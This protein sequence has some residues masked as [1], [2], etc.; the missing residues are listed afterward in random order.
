MSDKI[1]AARQRSRSTIRYALTSVTH[2]SLTVYDILGR[3]VSKLV[4]DDEGP[5]YHT[6]AWDAP[7]NASGVY[8]YM[9]RTQDFSEAKKMIIVR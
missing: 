2:V 9:M 7:A 8:F 5:G 3:V 1:P 4:D 6:I